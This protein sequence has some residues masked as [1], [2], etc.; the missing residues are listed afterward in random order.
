[1]QG[2]W[3][4]TPHAPKLSK[5]KSTYINYTL[6]E[7]SNT[8]KFCKSVSVVLLHSLSPLKGRGIPRV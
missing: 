6:I 4:K 8:H 7:Q 2:W 1:M 5:E 3:N